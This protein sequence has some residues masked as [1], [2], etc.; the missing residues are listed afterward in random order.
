MTARTTPPRNALLPYAAAMAMVGAALITGNTIGKGL[1]AS[2]SLALLMLAVTVAAWHGGLGP[3]LLATVS[4]TLLGICFFDEPSAPAAA[5]PSEWLRIGVPLAFGAAISM[6]FELLRR[7][8]RR[9]D[10]RVQRHGLLRKLREAE[11]AR[12]GGED[13]ARDG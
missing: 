13:V 5:R 4:G 2:A 8:Q 9:A 3:G 7:A 6:M 1:T 10:A 11:R 12:A